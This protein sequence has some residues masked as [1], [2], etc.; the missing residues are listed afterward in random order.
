MIVSENP[1]LV[2]LDEKAA[3]DEEYALAVRKEAVDLQK[4]INEVIA[5]LKADG[6]IENWV[7]E[8]SLS[9]QD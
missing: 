9:L 1:G 7:E 5:E 6:S 3:E 2:L 8:Y 4:V